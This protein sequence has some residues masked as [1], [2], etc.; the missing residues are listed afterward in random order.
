M[1]GA[2]IKEEGNL[3]E[4]TFQTE[5][6]TIT[7]VSVYFTDYFGK[8]NGANLVFTGSGSAKTNPEDEFDQY[9]GHRL[10]FARALQDVAAEILSD[11]FGKARKNRK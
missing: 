11:Y 5:D 7:E 4:V 2:V 8:S 1:S 6:A 9:L 3:E 10:A